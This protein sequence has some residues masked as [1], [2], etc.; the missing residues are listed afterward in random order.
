MERENGWQFDHHQLEIVRLR[1]RVL[2]ILVDEDRP[3]DIAQ[4]QR[5]HELR[6]EA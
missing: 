3:A 4:H 1:D 5:D 2:V 6:H